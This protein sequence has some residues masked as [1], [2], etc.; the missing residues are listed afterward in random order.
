MLRAKQEPLTVGQE[1]TPSPGLSFA[2]CTPL[3]ATAP[4]SHPGGNTSRYSGRHGGLRSCGV[5]EVLFSAPRSAGPCTSCRK[6]GRINARSTCKGGC[7]DNLEGKLLLLEAQRTGNFP[8]KRGLRREGW[9]GEED[10]TLPTPTQDA[11]VSSGNWPNE[12]TRPDSGTG[13]RFECWLPRVLPKS[14]PA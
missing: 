10:E 11:G 5:T 8:V 14:P 6:T 2:P 12:R 13:L 9:A 3:W 1:A 7:G 4:T